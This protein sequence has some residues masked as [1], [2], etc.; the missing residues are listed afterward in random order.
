MLYVPMYERGKA[1]LSQMRRSTN[2]IPSQQKRIRS[3]LR[4]FLGRRKCFGQEMY[5]FFALH[6]KLVA[7]GWSAES[8][9]N[10][11]AFALA[12][13]QEDGEPRSRRGPGTGLRRVPFSESVRQR[14]RIR[15]L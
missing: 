9:R 5:T 10:Q 3:F 13:G 8:G 6:N 2:A 14:V 4:C 15:F 1:N 11:L 7:D 12:I